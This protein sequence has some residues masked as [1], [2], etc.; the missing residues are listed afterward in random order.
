MKMVVN[1]PKFSRLHMLEEKTA[2]TLES[3][4]TKS[5]RLP[6]HGNFRA[7]RHSDFIGDFNKSVMDSGAIYKKPLS[8]Y[9]FRKPKFSIINF[10]LQ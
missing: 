5:A 8:H 10:I 4:G 3:N 9:G 6:A 7:C 1:I 2:T